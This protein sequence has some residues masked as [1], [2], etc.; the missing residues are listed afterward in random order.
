M[1][2]TKT[3]FRIVA[4]RKTLSVSMLAARPKLRST[5]PLRAKM[6]PITI[7]ELKMTILPMSTEKFIETTCPED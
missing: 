7:S 5:R 1:S 2:A 4:G 3:E 6:Y